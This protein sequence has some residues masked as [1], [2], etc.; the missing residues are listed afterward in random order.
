MAKA[1]PNG[2]ERCVGGVIYRKTRGK[3]RSKARCRWERYRGPIPA[4]H[5]I[6]H[7]DGDR[8]NC[9]VQNLICVPRGHVTVVNNMIGRAPDPSHARAAFAWAALRQ[10]LTEAHEGDS[11]SESPFSF[12]FFAEGG[13]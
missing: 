7:L 6:V 3:W 8:A 11:E 5:V 10:T 9:G 1:L 2:A 4:G 13:G 12:P